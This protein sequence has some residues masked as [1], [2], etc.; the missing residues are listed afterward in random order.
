[1]KL[2]HATDLGHGQW[3]LSLEFDQHPPTP[4]SRFHGPLGQGAIIASRRDELDLLFYPKP[5]TAMPSA[6]SHIELDIQAQ[7]TW[8]APTDSAHT[9]ITGSNLGIADAI[10]SC[11]LLKAQQQKPA[12]V[13]FHSNTPFPFRPEPSRIMLPGLPA[14]VIATM[15]LLE[16]WKIPCRLARSTWQPG[17]FEGSAAALLQQWRTNTT[18]NTKQLYILNYA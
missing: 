5:D 6:G 12:L 4:G 13:I 10:Y 3:Q 8:Q 16:D 14:D 17:C 18:T 1:M 11:R 15:P 9:V 7:P 2:I